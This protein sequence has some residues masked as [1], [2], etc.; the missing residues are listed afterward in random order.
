MT[1]LKAR[2]PVVCVLWGTLILPCVS[3]DVPAGPAT[4]AA[5][6]SV[7]VVTATRSAESSLQLPVSIDRV[8]RPSIQQGQLAENLSESLVQVPG[9]AAE[10]RQNYAQDVQLSIR[11]FGARSSFGVRGVRLYADGIPGTMPDGQGQVS[12]FDLASTDHI[13]VL[14][15]PFS[16]LYGNSSGGVIALFTED[17]PAGFEARAAVV[18]GAFNQQKYAVTLGGTD[19]ALNYL[20]DA[21]HFETDGFR[22][23]SAAQRNNFNSKLRLQLDSGAK[24]TLV[25]NAVE[26]PYVQD[27]LGLTRSQ[28]AADPQQAG[29]NAT[30][31]DTRKNLSQEQLGLIY[32]QNLASDLLLTA[33]LYAGHRAT[34]QYQAILKSAQTV[35]TSPGGVIDLS[36]VFAGADVHASQQLGLAGTS[37]K[38]VYGA[39]YDALDEARLGFLNF[40][41]D[42][43]GVA[44]ALRRDQN[45]RVHD[46]DEYLQAEW[47]PAS[48]WRLLA[49]MR[50]SAVDVSSLD[51]LAAASSGAVS[52]VHY[53]AT[54]PVAGISFLAQPDLALYVA[55]G[56]G[57]ETPTLNDLAYRSVDGNPPGL[58]LGLQPARSDNYEAGIKHAVAGF[59]LRMAAFYTDTR[60]ELAV[61]QNSGGRTVYQNIPE[62]QRRGLEASAQRDL[63][64][65][66]H[67]QISYTWLRAQVTQSYETCVLLPCVPETVSDGRRLPAVPENAVYAALKWRSAP[68]GLWATL[69]AVGRAQIYANDLNTAAAAGFW[70][71]NLQLGMEQRRPAWQWSESLR[72]DNLTNH[73]YVDSVIVNESNGRYFEPEPG[74]SLYLMFTVRH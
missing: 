32:E 35:A 15:G 64:G 57:F 38:L 54:D 65:G 14:R 29:S 61:Q 44:G 26:T 19:A 46:L 13:E 45:N 16:A 24:V 47:V 27:P 59:A 49:G 56:R 40:V 5:D 48:R 37:M 70:V 60:N 33:T 25:A 9:V 41:G 8:E 73:R 42:T 11:G 31:Y 30:T 36:R 51:Y 62:T 50:H 21:A 2:Y 43:L 7:V 68:R 39:S 4:E 52:A 66:F 22:E 10:N 6:L 34:T 3:A 58:N 12:Q 67:G 17:G 28:L 71:E 63:G 53:Q 72:L 18:E 69:E 23:H 20:I 55:Y 74:R 1:S